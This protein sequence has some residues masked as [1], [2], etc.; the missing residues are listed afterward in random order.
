[1]QPAEATP[2]YD[3][4]VS[5]DRSDRTAALALLEPATGRLTEAVISTAPE[6]LEAWW[7]QLVAAHPQAQLAVA[8]EQPAPNLLAFFVTRRP[9]VAI[10]AL[11]PSATWAYRQSLTVSRARTD[12]SDARDQALFVRNHLAQLRPWTPPPA[13]VVELDR[14]CRARRKLV[15]QRTEL[16][17]RLQAALKRFFPQALALMH[18]DLW[19][20]MNLAFLRKWPSAQ[21]LQAAKLATVKAFFHHHGSRSAARWQDRQV[22]IEALIP[23]APAGISDQLETAVIVDQLEVIHAG[24]QRYDQAIAELFA[25]QGETA[26]RIAALPGAG[27]TLGPRVWVALAKYANNCE[28]ADDLVAAVGVAPVTDQSGKMHKVYRRLR[29]DAYTRQSIVEWAKESWKHSAWARAYVE[30][31]RARDQGFHAIIR[32]LAGKWLRILWKCWKDGL[33][34]D[35]ARYIECLRAKGSRLVANIPAHKPA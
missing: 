15:D 23:L 8:F 5:L 2:T 4:I 31:R 3:L 34:Y 16:T 10:Y 35:E 28:T 17:N 33:A 19:R 14:L 18:E 27:P 12:Q 20:P 6:A 22:L 13:H 9:A 25:Q 21:K 30:Q 1:M 7:Q 11:N 32:S 29:C 24:V 26:E